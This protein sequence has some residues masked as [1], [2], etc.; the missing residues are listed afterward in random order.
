[1]YAI[2]ATHSAIG[3]LAAIS[4]GHVDFA[5]RTVKID[6]FVCRKREN[7]RT[8]VARPGQGYLTKTR[9]VVWWTFAVARASV[10]PGVYLLAEASKFVFLSARNRL[11][12]LQHLSYHCTNIF[13]SPR[14]QSHSASRSRDKKLRRSNFLPFKSFLFTTSSTIELSFAR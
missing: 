9:A 3:R 12:I 7:C 5:W 6:F 8:P 11:N 4:L 1:M 13:Y 2:P 10:V 14:F